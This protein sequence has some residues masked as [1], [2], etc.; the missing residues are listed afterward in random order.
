MNTVLVII[1]GLALI[2]VLDRIIIFR[3]WL[4]RWQKSRRPIIVAEAK[5]SQPRRRLKVAYVEGNTRLI[6]RSRV[7]PLIVFD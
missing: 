4:A 7:K 5:K 3:R 2:G 6:G 1:V